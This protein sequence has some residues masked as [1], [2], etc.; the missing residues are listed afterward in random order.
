MIITLLVARINANFLDLSIRNDD[1]KKN[2][3]NK[4]NKEK[5]ITGCIA[6]LGEMLWRCFACIAQK[7]NTCIECTYEK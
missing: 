7:E 5:H 3:T 1:K 2:Y 6:F 4:T